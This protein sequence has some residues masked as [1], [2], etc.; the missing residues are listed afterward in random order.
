MGP[1]TQPKRGAAG[2]QQVASTRRVCTLPSAAS[3]LLDDSSACTEQAKDAAKRLKEFNI[4]RVIVSPF[5]R[6]DIC[7]LCPG[8]MLIPAKP[9]C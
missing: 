6:W 5:R 2:G 7:A 3:L 8:V 4:D 9:G 1:S